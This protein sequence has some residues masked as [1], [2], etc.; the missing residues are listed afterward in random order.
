MIKLSCKEKI[1]NTIATIEYSDDFEDNWD[2][3]NQGIDI[4]K[5]HD[6]ESEFSDDDRE[7]L[8]EIF[9]IIST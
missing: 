6:C 7:V 9:S 2:L 1:W 3:F 5:S 4:L 8:E